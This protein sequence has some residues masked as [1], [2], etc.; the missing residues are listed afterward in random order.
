MGLGGLNYY[1]YDIDKADMSF[2]NEYFYT[3]KDKISGKAETINLASISEE[4]IQKLP[5]VDVCFMFKLADVLDR[6]NHKQSEKIITNL[7]SKY[8]VVS[9]AKKTITGKNM[10]F[11]YRGWI[12]RMLERVGLKFEKIEFETEVFYIIKR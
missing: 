8:I 6:K 4:E 3:M 2:I 11:P 10:N 7:N 9:F 12:E 5:K 1:A